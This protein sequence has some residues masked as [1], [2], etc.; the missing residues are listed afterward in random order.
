MLLWLYPLIINIDRSSSAL[1]II[2]LDM[3]NK[4]GDK[5]QPCQTSDFVYSL[6]ALFLNVLV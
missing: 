4:S 6:N 2:L 3:L 5:T 1:I